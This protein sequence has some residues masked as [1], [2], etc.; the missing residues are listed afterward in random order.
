MQISDAESAM[1]LVQSC[2][3]LR[4]SHGWHV[5]L[6]KIMDDLAHGMRRT[7]ISGSCRRSW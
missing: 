4:R 7:T 6:G 2:E 5:K 3:R 1:I